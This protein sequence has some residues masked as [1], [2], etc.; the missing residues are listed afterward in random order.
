MEY[1]EFMEQWEIKKKNRE[2]RRWRN[3]TVKW[4]DTTAEILGATNSTVLTLRNQVKAAA[5]QYADTGKQKDW[6]TARMAILQMA[7]MLEDHID[8]RM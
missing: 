3:D 5:S 2:R 1:D 6:E 4:A 8:E 7:D